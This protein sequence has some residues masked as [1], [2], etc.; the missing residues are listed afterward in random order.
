MYKRFANKDGTRIIQTSR[1]IPY[2]IDYTLSIWAN[3][4]EDIE[5]VLYQIQIRFD[6]MAEWVVEDEY[7]RGSM[8]GTFEGAN[9]NTDI[10][11]DANQWAKV[12]YDVSIKV[13]G[14][15]PRSGRITPTVLGKVTSIEDLDSGEFFDIVKSN[16]REI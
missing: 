5:N 2:L 8:F 9:D 7:M 11:I 10:D 15:I 3:R 13:E 4:K 1:E 14:W 12:R 6:P 16:P